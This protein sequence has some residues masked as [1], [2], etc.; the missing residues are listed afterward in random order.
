MKNRLILSFAAAALLTL[1][2]IAFAD[3]VIPADPGAL[4]GN[5]SDPGN[6]ARVGYTIAVSD[7]GTNYVV[8][9]TTTD[10]AH[11][12]PFANLYFDT[13]ANNGLGSNLGFEA[14]QTQVNDAFIPGVGGSNTSV[15]GLG[16]T[17]TFTST[18]GL[19]TLTVT[20][21]NAFFLT[22][23][24]GLGFT[25]TPNGTAVSLHLSQT[26]GYSVV[27]GGALF[28]APVEL[29]EATVTAAVA[30][31]PEPAS[32]TYMALSGFGLLAEA[33]R[34]LRSRKNA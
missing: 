28:P 2:S 18:A 31:V 4:E 26:F 12:L 9:F 30:P 34:R 11:A 14:G 5:F 7:D 23:P 8:V 6:T 20:I 25:K 15:A 10:V 13:V 27:G 24:L 16:L 32:L 19:D 17:S 29:G 21:P 33:G 1:P 22:D 3:T